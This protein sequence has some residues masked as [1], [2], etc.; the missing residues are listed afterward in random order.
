[1]K[2][3]DLISDDKKIF[4]APMAGVTDRA[5]REIA[6]KFGAGYVVSEMISSKAI[7][8]RDKKTIQ[9]MELSEKERP[10]AIQI[11]G[12]DPEI[13]AKAAKFAI[14]QNPDA[15][16]INMG[17]PAPKVNKSGAGA[18]LMKN[19]K[20]C[21]EIVNKVKKAVNIPVTVKIRKGWDEQ[22]VNAVE[23][24]KICEE[25]GADAIA[26]HA[27]TRVQMY[28]GK[29]D[30]EK[31]AKVKAVVNVPVIGNGDVTNAWDA[32]EMFQKTNCDYIMIGRAAI[33]NP[34]IFDE[35]NCKLQGKEYI[36]PSIK[37]KMNTMR[38]HI[39][40]LCVQKGEYIGMKEAR[41][42]ICMYI[43]GLKN[44]ANFRNLACKLE[45]LDQFERF[46]S[47]VLAEQ[48]YKLEL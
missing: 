41:R 34:F 46:I 31:I 17:C 6:V 18:L 36:Y 12:D 40:N 28:S 13:I 2:F 45:N 10:C 11:F 44:A 19:P 25:A 33:G 22:S 8:F 27:K 37:E 47:E 24:A 14:L 48:D 35:I 4:L 43:K 39:T 21:F 15:I 29:C 9:L 1:M 5:F 26:V 38:E 23:I 30:L 20:L 3:K 16:D 42:H 7:S 32:I